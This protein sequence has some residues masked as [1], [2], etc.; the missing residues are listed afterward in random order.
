MGKI[1]KPVIDLTGLPKEPAWYLVRTLHNNE[2]E[3]ARN[4]KRGLEAK[5]LTD[6]I[7]EIFVP[8]KVTHKE[9]EDKKG[10]KT[11][12]EIKI[13]I[14]E[15]YVYVKAIMDEPVW[16]YLRTTTGAATVIA[17]GGHPGVTEEVDIIRMKELCG[18]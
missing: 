18:K 17:P 1:T 14:L 16:D 6:K 13:K 9:V 15:N 3:Y 4:L 7:V 12:K 11:T 5:K 8:I 10:K 2:E